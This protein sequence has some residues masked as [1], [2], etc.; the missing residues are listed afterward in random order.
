MEKEWITLLRTDDL[1]RAEIIK[2]ALDDCEINSILL[3][4]KD[5]SFSAFGMVEIMVHETDLE[6]AEKIL[7]EKSESFSDETE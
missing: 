2:A 3:N 6:Y 5:S 1:Y 7:L 4:Q